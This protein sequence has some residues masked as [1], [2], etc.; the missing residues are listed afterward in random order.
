MTMMIFDDTVGDSNTTENELWIV[1][2][3][4]NDTIIPMK[5]DTGAVNI[6]GSLFSNFNKEYYT[7]DIYIIYA[8][9]TS[10]V[11]KTKFIVD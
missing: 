4:I 1:P 7:S 11:L 3:N 8:D 2:M 6:L 10:K 5:L 9:F